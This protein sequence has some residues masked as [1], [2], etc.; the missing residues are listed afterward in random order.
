[1]TKSFE[2]VNKELAREML[3]QRQAV[4]LDVRDENSFKEAHIN[5]AVHLTEENLD[6]FLTKT[7]KFRPIICYC[8]HGF[9]SQQVAQYLSQNGFTAV[10]S[11]EGGFEDWRQ[12]YPISAGHE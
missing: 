10:Y 4:A 7:E 5:G 6:A 9:S 11:L 8:Y 12:D 1:M 3:D 2:N